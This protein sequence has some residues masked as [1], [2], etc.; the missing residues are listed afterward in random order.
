MTDDEDLSVD[1]EDELVVRIDLGGYGFCII[2]TGEVEYI[3]EGVMG[4]WGREEDD[5]DIVDEDADRLCNGSVAV[6]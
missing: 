5:V 6:V 4:V 1:V 2:S 3:Y